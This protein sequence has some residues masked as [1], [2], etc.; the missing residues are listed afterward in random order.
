LLFQTKSLLLSKIIN[1]IVM[2]NTQLLPRLLRVLEEL[3]ENIKLARLRRKLSAAQIAERAGISRSTLWQIER[4]APNVAMGSYA[5][6]LFVLGLEKNLQ[7]IAADDVLGRKLQD[8]G[9][10]SGKRAPKKTKKRQD[11]TQ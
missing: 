1:I 2:S 11:E 4:G 3:G 7:Q 8:A 10:L 9:I 6:V 5:Q